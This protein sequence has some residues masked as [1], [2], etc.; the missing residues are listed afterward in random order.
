MLKRRLS[1]FAAACLI[2]SQAAFAGGP[3]VVDDLSEVVADRPASSMGILPILI[4]GVAL[5]AALCGQD[6]P[7]RRPCGAPYA[8]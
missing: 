8:C 4:V 1:V 7:R 2:S 5:C 6:E 3:V